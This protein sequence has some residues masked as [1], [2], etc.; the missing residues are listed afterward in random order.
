V[1]EGRKEGTGCVGLPMI[2][3]MLDVF[4]ENGMNP[5]QNMYNKF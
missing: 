1:K 3:T 2:K 5:N 4:I